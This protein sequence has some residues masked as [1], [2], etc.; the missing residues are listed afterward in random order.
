MQPES[1]RQQLLTLIEHLPDSEL[2][3]V[4]RMLCGFFDPAEFACLLAAED[5]TPLDAETAV[6]IERARQE[7]HL[8]VPLDQIVTTPRS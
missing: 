6:Q 5:P 1:T 8:A 7:R 2:P 3:A 4:A